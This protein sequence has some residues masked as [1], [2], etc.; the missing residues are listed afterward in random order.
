MNAEALKKE[1]APKYLAGGKLKFY[2]FFLIYA[3]NKLV[4][5]EKGTFKGMSPELEF[6]ECYTQS[7]ILYRR[8]GE[9]IYLDLSRVFRKVAHK[10]YRV[11]LKKKMIEKNSKFLNL[12]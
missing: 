4:C 6:M 11:L 12:V 9:E 7:L 1:F 10:V 3:L 5:I 2:R 8:E